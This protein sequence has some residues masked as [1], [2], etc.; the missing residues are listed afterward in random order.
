MAK[1]EFDWNDF[2]EPEKSLHFIQHPELWPR[3]QLPVKRTVERERKVGYRMVTDSCMEDGVMVSWLGP[4]IKKANL[5]ML[6]D[7]AEEFK[8]LDGWT[9]ESFQDLV[10]DGWRVD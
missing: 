2:P 4:V 10:A 7:T 8:A 1:L 5:F 9:Y 6:P 3:L